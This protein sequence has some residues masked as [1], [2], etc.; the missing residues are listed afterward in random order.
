MRLWIGLGTF[1]NGIVLFIHPCTYILLRL[2]LKSKFKH[3]FNFDETVRV[4]LKMPV[5]VYD[6]A[7]L[8]FA[9]KLTIFGC[10]TITTLYRF[11]EM[12]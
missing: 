1:L 4:G 3:V 10:S 11:T 6:V 9:D 7:V 12:L 2:A 5:A 8:I